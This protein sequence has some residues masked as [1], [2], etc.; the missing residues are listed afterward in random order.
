ML[1]TYAKRI[2]AGLTLAAASWQLHAA[3]TVDEVVDRV[4]QV[5]YYQGNS[6]R[7][8]VQMLIIDKQGRKRQR[9]FTILRRDLPQSD[10][11]ENRAYLGEQQFYVYFNRPAD[12]NKMVFMVHKK[13]DRDDDRWLYLPALDLVKRIA[14][15]D[16]RT[17]FVGSDYFYEDVSGRSID[18]DHHELVDT[19]DNFY[20]LKHTPKDAKSVEFDH[21]LMYVH[22]E[23]FVPVQTEYFDANGAKYRIAKAL[24]VATIQGRPTVVRASMENLKTG[25][26]TLMR[27]SKVTYD[28]GI[29]ADIFSERYLR[30]APTQ[31]LR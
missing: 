13:L 17:S 2:F 30:A 8:Q 11:I 16:K 12:V 31:Y 25:S 29:P 10:A 9:S 21:Y 22:K 1:L 24:K 19:T 3:P 7:A 23:S 28:I 14:A 4:N 18:A 20:V 15:T 27:Y 6:G 5:A 26:K